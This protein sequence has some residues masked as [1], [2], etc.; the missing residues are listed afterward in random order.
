MAMNAVIIEH[1]QVSKLPK[2]WQKLLTTSKE[3]RVTVRIEAEAET[4]GKV[5]FAQGL[6]AIR[7]RIGYQGPAVSIPA[8]NKA[9]LLEAKRRNP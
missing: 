4:S 3:S 6:A 2:S 8:M 7:R 5:P 9:I 1:V